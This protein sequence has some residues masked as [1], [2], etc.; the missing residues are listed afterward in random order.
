MKNTLKNLLTLHL[1]VALLT[2]LFVSA[3]NADD[4]W[5]NR[6]PNIAANDVL[7]P[8]TPDEVKAKREG[9]KAWFAKDRPLY[10]AGEFQVDLFAAGTA[11]EIDDINAIKDG[12]LGGGIGVNYFFTRNIGIGY[13]ARHSF[14]D[15]ED[16]MNQMAGSLFVRFPIG[17]VS[18]YVFAGAGFRYQDHNFSPRYHAGAG[19]EFRL[20]PYVG[21][22][23]DLRFVQKDLQ[24][25]AFADQGYV[26]RAGIRLSF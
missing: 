18:P 11:Q 7:N 23:S 5:P 20:S 21:L 13:E 8:E 24:F 12:D 4:L 25:N 19:I 2:L 14:K 22:F 26:G 3:A 17:H 6:P 9:I 16:F 15:G 1:F 10:R